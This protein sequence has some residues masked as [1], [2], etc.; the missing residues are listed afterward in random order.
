MER[1]INMEVDTAKFAEWV[2]RN[3]APSPHHRSETIVM[4]LANAVGSPIVANSKLVGPNA[5][6]ALARDMDVQRAR[7]S[8]NSQ[9][10]RE[11]LASSPATGCAMVMSLAIQASG[12]NPSSP[13][14]TGNF[15]GF[16][17]YVDQIVQCPVFSIRVRDAVNPTMSGDWNAIVHQIASE[18]VG[19]SSDDLSHIVA[20]LYSLAQ[21][22]SS[23][24]GA[25]ETQTLFVQNTLNA[26][27][28]IT[29]YMYWSHVQMVTNV[30][31]GGKHSPDT[32]TNNASLTLYRNVLQFN[33][34]AWPSYAPIIIPK[35]AASLQGW[36]NDT[37]T[38]QGPVPVN[39]TH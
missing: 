17:A 19:I 20:G 7:A 13:A 38:P 39:W 33:S 34:G 11:T 8:N 32:V 14:A 10:F 5:Q 27:A 22:A 15:S 24:P 3:A 9:L 1:D 25:N 29:L 36:L 4:G 12:Y 2:E 28:G 30:Q 26:G 6:D 23:T 16:N 31:S 37:T 35:T 21:A 18:Y